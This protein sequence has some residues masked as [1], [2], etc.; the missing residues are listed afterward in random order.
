MRGGGAR[1][2]RLCCRCVRRL[3][4][5]RQSQ[6]DGPSA[7]RAAATAR[8]TKAEVGLNRLLYPGIIELSPCFDTGTLIL[9]LIAPG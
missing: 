7:Q 5:S 2:E 1:A 4:T 3:W 8:E 6:T 9:P